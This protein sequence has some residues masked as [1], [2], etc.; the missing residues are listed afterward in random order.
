MLFFKGVC[1]VIAH[2]CGHQ[3]LLLAMKVDF[4]LTSTLKLKAI[5][6]NLGVIT[7]HHRTPSRGNLFMTSNPCPLIKGSAMFQLER[8]IFGSFLTNQHLAVHSDLKGD[9]LIWCGEVRTLERGC[10]QQHGETSY[11]VIEIRLALISPCIV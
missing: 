3:V 4:V 9:C 10:L 11:H 7:Y 2:C 8:L 5:P 1:Y 6:N